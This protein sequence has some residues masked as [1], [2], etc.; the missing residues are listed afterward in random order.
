[1]NL[2][3]VELEGFDASTDH[4]DHLIRWVATSP[5]C[6]EPLVDVLEEVWGKVQSVEPIDLSIEVAGIDL[7]ITASSIYTPHYLSNGKNK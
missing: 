2:Y 1:M 5:C 4:T 3:Q 6:G 7:I